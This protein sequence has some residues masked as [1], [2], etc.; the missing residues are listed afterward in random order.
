MREWNEI[1]AW[2]KAQREAL[3]ARRV[4][5][6]KAQR[7]AWNAQLTE[8]LWRGFP[9]IPGMV[10]GF[11][12]PYKGEFDA[13]FVIRRWREQ[14]VIAAL[15]EVAA[16]GE[17]LRFRKWWPGAALAPG[18][19]DIPVPVGTDVV[20]PDVALVPMNGFDEQGFRLGYGG[21]FFDRTLAAHDRRMLAIG[22]GFE[23]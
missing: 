10:A 18:V 17:P 7:A 13:R 2:R 11:C 14:G 19:Y 1:K 15:P 9:A 23:L 20:V 3:I 21:G 4:A 12:W 5:L 6:D 22:V 16:K 8:L